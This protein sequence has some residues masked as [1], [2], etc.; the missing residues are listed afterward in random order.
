M[1]FDIK[2]EQLKAQEKIK[3]QGLRVL[4]CAG[5]GCV[6]NGSLDVIARFTAYEESVDSVLKCI[7]DFIYGGDTDDLLRAVYCFCQKMGMDIFTA[8]LEVSKHYAEGAKKYGKVVSA[9]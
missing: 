9:G 1:N 7:S 6:A 5:T 4:V 2:A 3:N 8:M